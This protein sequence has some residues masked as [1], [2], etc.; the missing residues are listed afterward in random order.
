MI[1]PVRRTRLPGASRFARPKRM[2][3]KNLRCHTLKARTVRSAVS[4]PPQR[5]CLF[6]RRYLAKCMYAA[7][8]KRVA[9]RLAAVTASL[10][11][12]PHDLYLSVILLSR[13][14]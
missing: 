11:G 7:D 10:E 9:E 8:G 3:Y 5:Y 13:D 6:F 2:L 1:G 14:G 4:L 12:R